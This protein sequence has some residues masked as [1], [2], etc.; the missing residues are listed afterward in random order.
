MSGILRNAPAK[1]AR[2]YL[3]TETDGGDLRHA[4]RNP[5]F[6][7]TVK[8]HG[9]SHGVTANT[10]RADLVKLAAA[11]LLAATRRGRRQE[12]IATKDLEWALRDHG[13]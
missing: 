8:S 1:Y 11:G 13:E 5:G 10:A 12:F 9:T 2:S 3:H 4:L 7:Y 6:R